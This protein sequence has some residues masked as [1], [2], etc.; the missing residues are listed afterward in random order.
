MIG[1]SMTVNTIELSVKM[2]ID[3]Y[4]AHQQ[5]YSLRRIESDNEGG[6]LWYYVPVKFSTGKAH[7]NLQ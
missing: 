5:L 1:L 7:L 3:I 4:F 2:N 6:F